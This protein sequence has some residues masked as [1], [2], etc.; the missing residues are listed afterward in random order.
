[1]AETAHVSGPWTY[2][3]LGEVVMEDN[4]EVLIAT[5][6]DHDDQTEIGNL[7]ASAPDMLAA[8]KD[9]L[10]EFEDATITDDIKTQVGWSANTIKAI[11]RAKAIVAK[12]EGRQP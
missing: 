12:A 3:D 10:D 7:V 4:F 5:I 9:M 8:L 2:L 11:Q 1:M 6:E